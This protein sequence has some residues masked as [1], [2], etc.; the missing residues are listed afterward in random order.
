MP[1]CEVAIDLGIHGPVL[2][3]ALACASGSAALVQARQ[4]ILAGEADAVICGGT[5][6]GITP[7]ML[8]GLIPTGALSRRNEDPAGAS[9]PFDAERDGFVYGEGAVIAVVESAEHAERRGAT[10]YA[11]V[12]S[13]ALTAD[14]FHVSAPSPDS[15]FAAEAIRQALQRAGLTPGDVDYVCA[16]ATATRAGDRAETLAI[17]RAF[18]TAAD[19]VAVSSPKSMTGHLIG[20]A[21][22]L[23]AMVCALAIRDSVVPP[24]INLATPDPD[25]DLDCV[26]NLARKMPV[27]AAITNAFGFGGQ[28]CV[29]VLTAPG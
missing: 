11:V 17:R 10:P 12:A 2:A 23:G 15:A 21:G 13:G 7:V 19:S 8:A 9:R 25:C 4:L 24:T 26:P 16:H 29:V 1:A 20:A 5:D 28:N 27:R 14:A 6:A 22:A 18:G 3:G